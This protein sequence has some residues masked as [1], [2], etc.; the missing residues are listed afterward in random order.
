MAPVRA[1]LALGSDFHFHVHFGD[2]E[3]HVAGRLAVPEP[4]ERGR[5]AFHGR[6]L[7]LVSALHSPTV[8]GT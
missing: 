4:A 5:R 7:R 8:D 1:F 2:V 3:R 6:L